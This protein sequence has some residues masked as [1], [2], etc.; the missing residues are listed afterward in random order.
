MDDLALALRLA[1]AADEV[2]MAAH[3]GEPIAHVD[4]EDGSPVTET[5]RAVETLL[6]DLVAEHRPADAFVGEE[7]GG[8]ATSGRRWIVDPVDGTRSFAAGGR[9]WATQ[10]ALVDDDHVLVGVTSAPAASARWWG[11]A[12]GARVRT[13][14]GERALRVAPTPDTIRWTCSSPIDVLGGEARAMADRLASIGT[15]VDVATHGALLVAEGGLDVCLTVD[16]WPWDYAAF[17]GIVTHAGGEFAYLD[18][19]RH[20]SGSR[21][22]LFTAG[23]EIGSAIAATRPTV[24]S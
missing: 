12:S 19:T 4:K 16:G 3:T 13:R 10:I 18:G 2:T 11:S 6:R 24:V 7:T 8:A 14:R 17:A 5:D 21:P 1:D 9:A 20:L 22:A 23:R 15:F